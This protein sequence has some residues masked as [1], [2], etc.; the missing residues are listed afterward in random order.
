MALQS[1]IPLREVPHC[2]LREV[3]LCHQAH[4]RN[5]RRQDIRILGLR[6]DIRAF[7]GGDLIDI[8]VPQS[9]SQEGESWSN[10]DIEEFIQSTEG[11]DAELPSP[12]Q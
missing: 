2:S 4:E 9:T 11:L 10:E 5:Q 8:P 7:L 6:N 3:M 12:S 1:G